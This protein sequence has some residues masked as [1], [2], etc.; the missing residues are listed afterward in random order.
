MFKYLKY[1]LKGSYKLPLGLLILMILWCPILYSRIGIW[2]NVGISSLA[3]LTCIGAIL[4]TFIYVIHL[5]KQDFSEDRGYLTFT[6]PL[7][8]R[9]ILWGKFLLSFI[10]LVIIGIGCLSF[11]AIIFIK[12]FDASV[13]LSINLFDS[14]LLISIFMGIVYLILSIFLAITLSKVALRNRRL[15]GISFVI[16]ILLNSA[17]GFLNL[18]LIKSFPQGLELPTGKIINMVDLNSGYVNITTSNNVLTPY[19]YINIA[20]AIFY[21]VLVIGLFIFNSYLMDRKMDL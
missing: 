7:K 12:G 8:G 11:V 1:E 21:V 2:S 3:I 15:G 4:T 5:Y 6:L 20:S 16:F 14:V 17:V 18:L 13:S 10:W 9:S 19:L